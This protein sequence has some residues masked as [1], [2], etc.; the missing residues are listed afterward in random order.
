MFSELLDLVL[1]CPIQ[2][3]LIEHNTVYLDLVIELS[4]MTSRQ[5][6]IS[7]T[8]GKLCSRASTVTVVKDKS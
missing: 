5:G 4:H 2:L 7:Q 8:V 6:K 1:I 3:T